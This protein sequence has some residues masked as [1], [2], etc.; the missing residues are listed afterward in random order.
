MY[1]YW[2]KTSQEEI[3]SRVFSSLEKNINYDAQHILG[4]P[5]SYLDD[6]VFNQNESFVKDAPW[7][8]TLIQNPNHI[9]CHT[10]GKSESFFKGTQEIELELLSICAEDIL[11]AK[12]DSYDGYVAAGG[13][14]ANMQ[15][16]WIY[17]NFYMQE[18]Q[19]SLNEICILCSADSHYS[20]AKAANVF[21]VGVQ[22]VAVDEDSRSISE[23]SIKEAIEIA[24]RS[25]FKYF[26]VVS[27]MMTTMFGSV[28]DISLYSKV[29]G[30][31]ELPFKIHI[32]AAYGGFY[33]PFVSSGDDL[34]FRNPHVSSVTLDA[35][36]MAQAPYGTGIFLI[37]KG[38]M[39]YANTREASY[40]EGE[41]FTLIGSRSGAN[42][43]AVWMILQKNGPFR[44]KEKVYILQKRS[45]WLC[46]ELDKKDIRYFREQG[47][48]IVTID[49]MKVEPEV[50][51]QFGLVPD[52]HDSPKWYK[53]IVME[54]VTIEK[55]MELVREL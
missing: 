2:K 10:L 51:K 37:R 48:N 33:Y 23:N 26:V 27:N 45:D 32:D 29:L 41:D 24:Q 47:S 7:I 53:V 4:I 1:S 11:Q 8:S 42:A 19:A 5:A 3:K 38:M 55:L 43:V 30:D 14:E 25:G 20:M 35:H 49:A 12:K 31:A 28:D 15:A 34:S 21:Q 17:R 46:E 13:T 50:A 52:H 39:Q 6:Q 44:W 36:K 16:I 18:H 54:H 9:G 22:K 40:V